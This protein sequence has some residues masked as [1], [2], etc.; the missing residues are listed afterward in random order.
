MEIAN[1]VTMLFDRLDRCGL[2]RE[3]EHG[4]IEHLLV[5]PVTPAEIMIA[6]VW[7]MGLIVLLATAASL[8]LVIEG[9]LHVPIEGS[10]LL[11]LAAV[12]LHLRHHVEGDFHAHD[13][14]QQASARADADADAAATRHAVRRGNT[15]RSHA[16]IVQDI[17]LVSPNSH[18]VAVVQAILYRGAGVAV[19]WLRRVA[20]AAIGAVFFGIAL[21]YFR[22]TLS[23]MA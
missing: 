9:A 18:L 20:I 5:M 6:K 7:S 14:P 11:F 3:R 1:T 17:M 22:K 23:K 16:T 12:A 2:I 4:T 21:T 8:V 10:V 13:R 15:R 19:V